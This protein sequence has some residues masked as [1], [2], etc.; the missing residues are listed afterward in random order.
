M[1]PGTVTRS[2]F[3]ACQAMESP[4]PGSADWLEIRKEFVGA[5]ECSVVCGT[6]EYKDACTLYHEKRGNVEPFQ[7]NLNTRLGEHMEP[8]I[9]NLY[10][11]TTGYYV[12]KPEGVIYISI[13]NPYMACSPDGLCLTGEDTPTR[14]AEFKHSSNSDPWGP[15]GSDQYPIDY[16]MQCQQCMA[17]TG[18]M[19]W[20]LAVLLPRGDFRIYTILRDDEICKN[21]SDNVTDFITNHV[22]PGVPPEPDFSKESA[23][24]LSKKLFP[25]ITQEVVKL[26]AFASDLVR[27]YR[28]WAAQEKFAKGE[29][30]KIKERLKLLMGE[31][32][33]AT[34]EGSSFELRR[35]SINVADRI[36]KGYSYTNFIIKGGKEDV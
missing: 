21:I 24:F 4:Q 32:G 31:C 1:I 12:H 14:G 3:A 35:K 18:L 36:T 16:F 7:G 15:S 33:K 27:E 25:G 11:E 8:F 34:I 26:P 13:C 20:D 10:E 23:K 29:C 2:P 28:D 5:S 9:R 6:S 19:V 30:E 22:I 17:V